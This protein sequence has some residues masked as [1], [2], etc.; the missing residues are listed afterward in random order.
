MAA[1]TPYDQLVGTLT[2]YMAAASTAE[3]AVN[4][5]PG[6]S[7]IELGC[8]EGDQVIAAEEGDLTKF[9][10]NCHQGPVKAV[11]PQEDPQV[12]GRIVSLTL[13]NI[14]R[15]IG[16]VADVTSSAGPPAIKRLAV[17]K[18]FTLTEYALLV[19]GTADSPYGNFAAQHYYPRGVFEGKFVR[20]R[21]KTARDM[22]DFI[23][24]VLE[25]DTQ[26]DGNELGWMT[27]QTS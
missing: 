18:G 21:G 2:F 7:W 11:R 10:D 27:A 15:L 17:K 9:Y 20:T 16:D 24:H 26:T 4:T 19:K 1:T 8:T 3:P 13:E 14:A 5:T 22:I 25:D 12:R 23:F 6:A